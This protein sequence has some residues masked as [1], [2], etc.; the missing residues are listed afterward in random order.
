M[1]NDSRQLPKNELH[2]CTATTL[3]CHLRQPKT[4]NIFIAHLLCASL[5]EFAIRLCGLHTTI[6]RITIFVLRALFP[7][8]LLDGCLPT[9]GRYLGTTLCA[10]DVVIERYHSRQANSSDPEIVSSVDEK[11]GELAYR[12]SLLVLPSDTP[13]GRGLLVFTSGAC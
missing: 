10:L 2:S 3:P 7:S 5:F 1:C 11:E 6:S 9:F 4:S 12:G 8:N 13:S